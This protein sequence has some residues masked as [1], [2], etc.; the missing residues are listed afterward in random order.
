M[1]FVL[2]FVLST[3]LSASGMAM[4]EEPKAVVEEI[5]AKAAKD[6]VKK[7]KSLQS[8]IN[9][10]VDFTTM[11]RSVLGAEVIKVSSADFDWFR[12][13]LQEII[14][15]TVYPNAPEFLAGVSIKYKDVELKGAK[16]VVKSEVHNK[17]D[18]TDVNYTLA[19][20]KD[21]TWKVIDI[22]LDGESWVA[23]IKEQVA[24]T[25]RSKEWAGL[26]KQL[27]ERLA[28]LKKD[29]NSKKI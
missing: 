3:F 29:E 5:F 20:G 9:A 11:A 8:S 26:K 14:T 21:G 7:D 4:A 19:R 6:E 2:L 25:M 23:S 24:E 22:S 16:A 1:K 18:T 13:T 28:K 10:N 12:S 17:A 15:R 27:S